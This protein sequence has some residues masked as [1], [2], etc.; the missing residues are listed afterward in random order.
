MPG[1]KFFFHPPLPEELVP[2]DKILFEL[3]KA[4]WL[5][6]LNSPSFKS[7]ISLILHHGRQSGI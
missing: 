6:V 5:C 7:L 1:K 2:I 4:E 3:F